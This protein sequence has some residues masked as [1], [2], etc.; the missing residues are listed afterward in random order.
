[1]P[2]ANDD[3]KIGHVFSLKFTYD[4]NGNTTSSAGIA[5]VPV[6][7]DLARLRNASS[8]HPGTYDF[9]N[10]ML[11]HGSLSLVY[12]GNRVSETMGGTAT[13]YLIDDKNPTHLPQVLDELQNGAVTRTYAYALTRISQNQQ[14]SGT[15][16]PSFYGYDGH[17]SVRFLSNMAG[18]VTDSYDYDAFG[19]PIKTSGTTPNQFLYSSERYDSSVGLYDLRARYYNQA[20]GRFWARDPVQGGTCLPLSF[21]PYIYTFDDP[22]NRID[23][24]GRDS[25]ETLR[26]PLIGFIASAGIIAYQREISCAFE[27][28]ATFVGGVA[29]N[30]ANDGAWHFQKTG[31]CQET[32]TREVDCNQVRKECEE[33]CWIEVSSGPSRGYGGSDTPML[34]RKCGRQMDGETRVLRLLNPL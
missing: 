5:N 21:N 3:V 29:A 33:E 27:W 8:G 24:T 18:S 7:L 19:M 11:T 14:I 10:R 34:L 25:V 22:A 32:V 12:D 16:T 31:P 26:L 9:E 2:C 4:T 30:L 20:T 17:L 1:M 15:W 6:P 23:P 13:K 28:A